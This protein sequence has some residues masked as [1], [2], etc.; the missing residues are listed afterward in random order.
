MWPVIVVGMDCFKQTHQ[1]QTE[2]QLLLAAHSALQ[3]DGDICGFL[4]HH[5]YLETAFQI[6]R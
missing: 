2:E 6:Q 1:V 3:E 5:L 4:C